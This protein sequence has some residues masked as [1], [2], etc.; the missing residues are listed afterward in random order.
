MALVVECPRCGAYT[1]ERDG[2]EDTFV[3][4]ELCA[5]CRKSDQDFDLGFAEYEEACGERAL[6]TLEGSQ[7]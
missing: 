3:V 4:E 5:R 7:G 6:T 2:H 1:S